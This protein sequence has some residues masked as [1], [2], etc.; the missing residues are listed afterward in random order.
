MT[1]LEKATISDLNFSKLGGLVNVVVQD[2]ETGE[3]LMFAHADRE[4]IERTLREG[5]AYFYS[6][7][8]AKLW[9]KGETSGNYMKVVEILVDCDGDA[10]IY[11]VVPLGPV[12]HLGSRTCFTRV[13]SSETV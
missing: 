11:R 6:R 3:V 12:C 5:L 13:L 9:L 4:A 1:E 7:S 10:V 8:R 2:I